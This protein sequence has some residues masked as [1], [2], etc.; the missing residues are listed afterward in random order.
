MLEFKILSKDTENDLVEY[1]TGL[2]PEAEGEYLAEITASLLEDEDCEYAL[3]A[4]SGCLAI[5]VFDGRYSF[6]YPVALIDGAD[7]DEAVDQIRAY[8]VKEEIPLVF[9]DVPCEELGRLI[10][11]FRHAN[12]DASDENRE[13]YTVS[14]LTEIAEINNVPRINAGEITLD[15]LTPE[16]DKEYSRL[17]KDEE[18]NRF[19]GYDYSADVSDP[20][21]FYFRENADG[22]FSR[23]VAM[24]FALRRGGE[25]IGEGILYAFDLQGG[26]DLAIRILPEYRRG[27]YAS[28]ALS[29]L[30]DYGRRIGL[31]KMRALV[32]KDNLPSVGLCKKCFDR[33]IERD[34]KTIE[35][36]TTF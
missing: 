26:C 11:H 25:F 28:M 10:S 36:I 24:C 21:D 7:G 13:N 27:G 30:I 19:W 8:A 2:V 22:E 16:D 1:I 15:A 6:V 14:V 32:F 35:F 33:Q 20:E 4:C 18:T 17:C 29:S 3:S 9:C 12:V 31:V 5:R 34:N 23:G